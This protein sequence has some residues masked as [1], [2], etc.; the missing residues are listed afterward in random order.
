MQHSCYIMG[1]GL[2][3]RTAVAAQALS[4]TNANLVQHLDRGCV[5]AARLEI[6]DSAHH[7]YLLD[8]LTYTVN[9]LALSSNH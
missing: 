1:R 7:Q 9:L 8:V 3:G 2:Y 6:Y 4:T 5:P